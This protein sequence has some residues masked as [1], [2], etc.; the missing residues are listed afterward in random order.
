MRPILLTQLGPETASEIR[1]WIVA[2]MPPWAE[3]AVLGMSGGIDSSVVAAL[4]K[5]A[6][7][8]H[9]LFLGQVGGR[10]E[11]L[12]NWHYKLRGCALPSKLNSPNDVVD[13]LRVAKQFSISFATISIE[14][15]IAAMDRSIPDLSD[16]DRGNMISRQRANV[17]HTLAAQHHSIVMGTGN[18]G[19]DYGVGY[20]TLGGDGFV[21][22][23]PL[24]FLYKR[25]VRKLG[26]AERLATDLVHRVSRAGLEP[27]QT[28]ETD[29]G[30]S[31]DFVE[32]VLEGMEQGFALN[33]LLQHPQVIAEMRAIHMRDSEAKRS[34]KYDNTLNGCRAMIFDVLHRHSIAL[35]KA[36]YIHAL[37]PDIELR[38]VLPEEA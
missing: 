22:M 10:R 19:E 33:D 14:D 15:Q 18:K 30:Y 21:Y 35:K 9:T 34:M 5:E 26:V 6:F 28:D 16:Y 27:N 13:A 31:Y 38:R 29:L 7:T 20:Y 17:L 4:T 8:E 32:L 25:L 1:S 11:M 37:V 24:G 12:E 36:A 2:N 23:N 3:G